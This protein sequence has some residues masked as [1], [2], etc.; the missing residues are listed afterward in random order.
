VIKSAEDTSKQAAQ[1]VDEGFRQDYEAGGI[2]AQ[3]NNSHI[4]NA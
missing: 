3:F 4:Q 2:S 1:A